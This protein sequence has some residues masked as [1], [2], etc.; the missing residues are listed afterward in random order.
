M[1]SLTPWLEKKGLLFETTSKPEH[2][3][4][5]SLTLDGVRAQILRVSILLLFISLETSPYVVLF[6]NFQI[7]ELEDFD[8]SIWT[9]LSD[10]LHSICACFP[11]RVVDQYNNS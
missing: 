11:Q 6:V 2:Y 10:G 5:Q 4:Y 8:G 1:D 7:S 9:V 3:S